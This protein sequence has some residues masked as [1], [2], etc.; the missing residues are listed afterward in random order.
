MRLSDELTVTTTTT[1]TTTTSTELKTFVKRGV[2]PRAGPPIPPLLTKFVA[3]Q[4]SSAC[5]CLGLKAPVTTTTT[6]VPTTVSSP[7]LLSLDHM[8]I[9]HTFLA[10]QTTTTSTAYS[11]VI[12]TFT[13]VVTT[14]ST[15]TVVSTTIF[16]CAPP[17]DY[18]DISTPCCPGSTCD[19]FSCI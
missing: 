17:G 18:C 15:S 19:E 12:T 11:V 5:S 1:T 16:T 9:T 8:D 2:I 3:A 6:T 10:L 13:S 14:S 4:I 7:A